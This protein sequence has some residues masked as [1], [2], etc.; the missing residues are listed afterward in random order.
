[1]RG[2]RYLFLLLL[3]L[4]MPFARGQTIQIDTGNDPGSQ[5]EIRNVTLPGG[6]ETQ[7][8]VITGE[9]VV[10]TVDEQRLEASHLEVDLEQRVVRIV[11]EGTLHSPDLSVRGEG[12]I[13]DL[14]SEEFSGEQVL[15]VTEAIDVTGAEATRI[16]G[17][18][19]V[20]SGEFSP[21]SRC[22]QEVEDFG[23]SAERIELYPGDRLVAWNATVLIRERPVFQ[24]PLLVVPL[25]RPDR[26]PRL[27]IEGGSLR[28]RARIE[29]DWP[30]VAGPD[31]FGTFSVRYWADVVPTGG[32]QPLGG[33]I[34][35]S[36]L[37]GGIDHRFY[38]ERGSGN[39]ELFYT[40]SF[41]DRT[42]LQRTDDEFTVR[43]AYQTREDL[44]DGLPAVDLLIERIDS[45][46]NRLLEYGLEVQSAYELPL[47][48]GEFGVDAT[49]LT[50]GFIDLDPDDNVEEP[51]YDSI[52][53]P[54]RTHA[55]LLVAPEETSFT[56][57]PLVVRDLQVDLGAF[58]D[59]SNPGNRS[60]AGSRYIDAGRALTGFSVEL[61]PTDL[62]SGFQVEGY[63]NF[64]G[65]YYSTGERQVDWDLRLAGEQS[66]G[67]FASLGVVLRRDTTEGETPFRFDGLPLRTRMELTGFLEL[68]PLPWLEA[69][70]ETGYV[71][72][73]SRRPDEEGFLPISSELILFGNQS[74]IDVSVSN[75]YDL[76][77]EDPGNLEFELVLRT[78]STPPRARLEARH[79]IDLKPTVPRFGSE[80]VDETETSMELEYSLEYVSVDMSGGYRYSAPP[81][82]EDETRPQYWLP[83]ELGVTAGTLSQSD[84]VPGLRV[85]FERN[86]NERETE[87][88]SYEATARI[89]EVE[90]RAQQ[91]FALP[92]RGSDSSTF[93]VRYRGYAELELR[94]FM[95]VRREWLG[96]PDVEERSTRYTVTLR[97]SPYTG[98]AEWELSYLTR[99]DPTLRTPDGEVGGYRDSALE[100]RMRLQDEQLGNSRF[101]VDLLST[102]E[103][104]DDLLPR[105]YLRRLGLEVA[106]D[107]EGVVGV[108]GSIGYRGA[109]NRATGELTQAQLRLDEVAVTVKATDSLFVGALLEDVWDFTGNDPNRQPFDLRPE[110]FVVWDRC[111][112]AL[113]GGWD[114]RSG[115]VRISL[116][117]PGGT[118]GVTQTLETPLVLPSREGGN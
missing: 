1:M 73:D 18:I 50:R 99:Y 14:S 24:L 8:Y 66:F 20:L 106:A 33:R 27:L 25:A 48:T 13:I 64:D 43:L 59:A 61:R 77:E 115:A 114:T 11:G 86:L 100:A 55:Q 95:L 15:I 107:I 110:L 90:L 83:L 79:L 16:P 30:Y 54:R 101:S 2:S 28:E 69:R 108:Q 112:W 58:E 38:D 10:I 42:T 49:F 40:P 63:S 62:W 96:L 12:L 92:A 76:E 23:F 22:G 4:A 47:W 17:Q 75:E 57:G 36:Y 93:T 56:V 118:E 19:D 84:Q 70:T 87:A 60:A 29:L 116:T 98:P 88:L 103:L 52:G 74:W 85:G 39:L 72:R 105:T 89:G 117:T 32:F 46:R 65:Y 67:N 45:R 104:E 53:T 109:V 7:I 82:D 91:R 78:P 6:E 41:I 9:H 26:Q 21:C 81:P 3:L 102:V 94:N 97:H 51:S 80:P 44:A 111:C 68:T 113:M 37:G 35:T 34:I 5:L 71:F 31:A